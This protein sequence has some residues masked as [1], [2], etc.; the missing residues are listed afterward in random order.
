MIGKLGIFVAGCVALCSAFA[1]SF[2]TSAFA[3][4][5]DAYARKGGCYKPSANDTT[6]EDNNYVFWPANAGAD[7]HSTPLLLFLPGHGAKVDD[8]TQFLTE[9]ASR[10]YFVIGLAYRNGQS[11]QNMC[12]YWA[13][14]A[15]YLLQQ[16]VDKNTYNGFYSCGLSHDDAAKAADNNAINPRLG[17][18]LR[19][20]QDGHVANHFQWM[21]YYNYDTD[22][23]NWSRIVIAGHSEGGSTATW[24]TKN[25]PVIAGITFEA[26]YS[27]L[28]NAPITD[29]LGVIHNDGRPLDNQDYTPWSCACP[30]TSHGGAEDQNSFATFL[31]NDD[32][33]WVNKLWV[34]LSSHDAGY[35]LSGGWRGVNMKGAAMA[36]GKQEH[37]FSST[38]AT[39]DGNKWWTYKGP[40]RG[41]CKGHAS[42]V[43]NDCYPTW[44]PQYW[45]KVLD[46]AH[47]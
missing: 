21:Q 40:P 47:P 15:S 30:Y 24:I 13:D 27:N 25:K 2:P 5:A 11:I 14:C 10:R 9:A 41:D 22:R 6:P 7:D 45:D 42:T 33:N 34:T 12:G 43:V 35:D 36:L 1:D 32:S 28:D 17:K 4:D 44:M 16:N 20:L 31:H 37:T 8:Y 23:V 39:L 18:F 46:A 3:P 26:P 19:H 29:R 38:P